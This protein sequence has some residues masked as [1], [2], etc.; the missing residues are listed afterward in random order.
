MFSA[1]LAEE[2]S[3]GVEFL[4]KALPEAVVTSV[5]WD[6][7]LPSRPVAWVQ[8]YIDVSDAE[9]VAAFAVR[10]LEPK[11]KFVAVIKGTQVGWWKEV[12]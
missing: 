10:S 3:A 2:A 7:A 8:A 1:S 12:P 9:P 5:A 6:P 4:R 11:G